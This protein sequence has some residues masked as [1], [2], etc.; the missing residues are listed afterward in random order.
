MICKLGSFLLELQETLRQYKDS[1]ND[2]IRNTVVTSKIEEET[3]CQR[4]GCT[5]PGTSRDPKVSFPV[6]NQAYECMQDM[7]VL[8]CT[9]RAVNVHF[10][11]EL[12]GPIVTLE[13]CDSAHLINTWR[14]KDSTA[15]AS[16]LSSNKFIIFVLKADRLNIIDL[17]YI[18]AQLLMR[19]V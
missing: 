8:S 5:L 12:A 14:W 16:H 17:W 15:Q 10:L 1:Q 2:W 4:S 3:C 7:M 13:E 9:V 18:I 6:R 19:I 11:F